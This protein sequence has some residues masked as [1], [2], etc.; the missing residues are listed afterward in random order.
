MKELVGHKSGYL[1]SVSAWLTL[2]KEV[3]GGIHLAKRSYE[4]HCILAIAR[5]L[6][7]TITDEDGNEYRAGPHVEYVIWSFPHIDHTKMIEDFHKKH[8]K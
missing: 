6:G 2:H 3:G 1:A 8:S 5:I 7:A 4:V